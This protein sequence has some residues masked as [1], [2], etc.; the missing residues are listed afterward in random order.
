MADTV[1]TH[2]ETTPLSDHIHVFLKWLN[3]QTHQQRIAMFLERTKKKKKDAIAKL[4][5]EMKP[6]LL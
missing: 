3:D 1:H 5:T 4:R 6:H 2:S